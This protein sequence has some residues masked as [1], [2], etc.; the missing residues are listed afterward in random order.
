MLILRCTIKNT[1][2]SRDK[3]YALLDFTSVLLFSSV[4]TA[5]DLSVQELRQKY[6][7]KKHPSLGCRSLELG[8]NQN[9]STIF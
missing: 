7:M 9:F 3:L 6:E 1:Q 2:W 8:I 5:H 4:A